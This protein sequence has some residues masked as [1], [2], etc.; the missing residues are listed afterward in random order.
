MV[1]LLR[2]SYYRGGPLTEV[3]SSHCSFAYW[4]ENALVRHIIDAIFEGKVDGVV[5]P[6][7]VPDVLDVSRAR[8]VLP[9]LVEGDRH[10][11]I[12]GVEGFFYTITMVNININI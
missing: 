5:L 10:H 3:R 11:T 8:E 12:G 7:A 9:V 6:F 1:I 2:W 4:F